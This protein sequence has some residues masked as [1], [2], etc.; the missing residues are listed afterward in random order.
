[1]RPVKALRS[2]DN[3]TISHLILLAGLFIGIAFFIYYYTQQLT[4]AHYD[5][6]AHLLVARRLVDS[7]EPGY[8]QMGAHWLPLIHLLYLPLVI[9]DAQ[10]RSGFLPSLISVFA[11]ALSGWLV[12]RISYRFTGSTAAGVF[13]AALLLANPNLEYL[14]SCPLTEPLYMMLFLLAMDRLI[15]WREANQMGMPWMAAVWVSLGGLCRYEGWYFLAGVML[16]LLHDFWTNYIPKRTAIRAG[17][18]FLAV[19]ALPAG[20]H[21]AY[22]FLRLGAVFFNKVAAGNPDPY[23]THK[24]PILSLLYHLAELSQMAAILPLL[25]ALIGFVLFLSQRNKLRFRAPLLLLWIPSLINISALYWGL[26]YR[27]RYSVLLLPAVAIFASLVLT[28][29]QAKKQAMLIMAVAATALP[30]LSWFF[31]HTSPILKLPPGP[32]ILILPAVALVLFVI[33]QVRS[34]HSWA[35]FAMCVLGM[36]LPA[37]A[38]EYR[39]M[40][41]EA[42]E[43]EFAEPQRREIIQYLRRDYDG[44]KILID[45][46][47]QAPLVYD[48]GLA[49]REFVYNEGG[50]VLWHKAIQNPETQVGWLCALKGDAVWKQLQVDPDWAG[51]YA[52]VVKTG[53]LSLYRIRH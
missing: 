24:R 16:L 37:L 32:G 27:L 53:S 18:V 1:M 34:W 36:Q 33:T 44:R 28:S 42:L 50:G 26:V 31:P 6:K 52:L 47:K 19:F 14:Q 41:A 22:I 25:L 48:S 39:P 30:W 20:V 45:M 35:L 9:F 17:A 7:L 21:F 10:Y 49:V 38:P 29:V 51:A 2:K 13:A 8:A 46:S 4:V 12:Y 11:F 5:A 3:E 23:L 43:H 40:V 15:A